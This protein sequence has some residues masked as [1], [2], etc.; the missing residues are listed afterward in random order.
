MTTV[1]DKV[2]FYSRD[3]MDALEAKGRAQTTQRLT[4]GMTGVGQR[5]HDPEVND[6]MVKNDITILFH[7]KFINKAEL[8]EIV[9]VCGVQNITIHTKVANG[10]QP[11]YSAIQTTPDFE[12]SSKVFL[13]PSPF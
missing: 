6:W 12:L 2:T 5:H 7:N 10:S 8:S 1:L 13:F 9:A 4:V 11:V 3:E